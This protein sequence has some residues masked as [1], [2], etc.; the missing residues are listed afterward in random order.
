VIG[1]ISVLVESAR[2]PVA[3]PRTVVRHVTAPR[4][5]DDGGGLGHSFGRFGRFGLGQL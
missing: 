4:N 3:A 1:R 5:A 2:P